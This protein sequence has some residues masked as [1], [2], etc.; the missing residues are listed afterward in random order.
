MLCFQVDIKIVLQILM[1]LLQVKLD[2]I[3]NLIN[4][5]LMLKCS[6]LNQVLKILFYHN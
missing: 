5:K 4:L 2:D 3:G 6:I 1:L